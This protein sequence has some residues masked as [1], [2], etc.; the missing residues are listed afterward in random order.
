MEFCVCLLGQKTELDQLS[1]AV[2]FFCRSI[3]VADALCVSVFF[4][5]AQVHNV[6]QLVICFSS[7]RLI[8]CLPNVTSALKATLE[9]IWKNHAQQ[10]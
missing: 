8:I 10:K 7:L 2:L 5:R 9:F 1:H 6:S 4:L 3:S